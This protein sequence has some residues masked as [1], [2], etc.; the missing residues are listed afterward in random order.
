[1]PRAGDITKVLVGIGL[2][3]FRFIIYATNFPGYS[4]SEIITSIV[5]LKIV[6][7]VVG[8]L[9]IAVGFFSL[10]SADQTQTFDAKS[11]GLGA[12]IHDAASEETMVAR[13]LTPR[14]SKLVVGGLAL[15][16]VTVVTTLEIRSSKME[17]E[18]RQAE[19]RPA[20]ERQEK[21]DKVYAN[22]RSDNYSVR[23]EAVVDLLKDRTKNITSLPYSP[24]QILESEPRAVDTLIS[25]LGKNSD[26][27]L[28]RDAATALGMIC[29]AAIPPS[30]QTL[31]Q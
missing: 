4:P 21:I 16:L 3:T 6:L 13:S 20:L 28:R 1:M 10:F 17:Y 5:I 7:L 30:L 27:S 8:V 25:M 15:A 2:V 23:R 14:N 12:Y 19:R 26:S 31:V 11:L 18:K 9:L 22:L 24:N 29:T